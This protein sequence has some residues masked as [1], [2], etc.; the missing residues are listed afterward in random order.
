MRN[1]FIIDKAFNYYITASI[2]T[3][4]ASQLSV[5]T[6][7]VIVGQFI[8]PEAL[9]SI[10]AA[11]PLTMAINAMYLLFAMGANVRLARLLGKQDGEGMREL[12]NTVW[13]S[14]LGV[15]LMIMMIVMAFAGPIS[16]ILCNEISISHYTADYLRAY[17][18]GVAPMLLYLSS[19]VFIET[20]GHPRT[21]CA[22][23]VLSNV[24]NLVLDLIFI[25]VM[26]YGISGS[27][28]ATVMS[29]ILGFI[30]VAMTGTRKVSFYKIQVLRLKSFIGNLLQNLKDGVPVALGNICIGLLVFLLNTI[31]VN[32][33]GVIGMN[34]WSICLQ[35]LMLS[36]VFINGTVSS[37]YAVGGVICG[38]EDW[39][40]LRLFERKVMKVLIM[41]LT[42]FVVLVEIDPDWL[43]AIFGADDKMRAAGM[44]SALRQF[45]LCE[46]PFAYIF[47]RQAMLQLLE[48]RS[49]ASAVSIAQL[50]LLL[51][52]TW[53]ASLMC[54][55]HVWS[56]FPISMFSVLIAVHVV[57]FFIHRRHTGTSIISL[58]PKEEDPQM[59]VRTMECTAEGVET[60]R[61]EIEAFVRSQSGD[62][63]EAMRRITALTTDILERTGNGNKRYCD[64]TIS[65][66]T[67]DPFVKIKDIQNAFD[68]KK[69]GYETDHE[70]MYGQNVIKMKL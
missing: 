56:S 63:E 42:I 55:E 31:I 25:G 9:S 48:Y 13:R 53:I 59:I 19:C 14:V 60:A 70:V 4:V 20:A 28:W 49:L 6:D 38:E 27:A 64:I 1:H 29:Y 58:I 69:F 43:A 65:Y 34:I 45:F 52:G 5:A 50:S 68:P 37:I 36:L 44:N 2:L 33:Q 22:I 30:L 3:A 41:S 32:A 54:P 40:G 47:V 17:S 66:K 12:F 15:G 7:A 16:R 57:I 35:I 10:N 26:G 21:V 51:A 23:M 18:V 61:G 46:V 67:K 8:S 24:L 11:T 39:I 62:A